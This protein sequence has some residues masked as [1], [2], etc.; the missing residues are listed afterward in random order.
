LHFISKENEIGTAGVLNYVNKETG[1]VS[2]FSIVRDLNLLVKEDLIE[3]IGG[4][5]ST[6][7][8]EKYDWQRFSMI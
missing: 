5:R 1:P 3:R 7:Y 8:R 4:G 2:R 6:K